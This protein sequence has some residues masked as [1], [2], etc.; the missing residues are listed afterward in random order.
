[1]TEKGKFLKQF[2]EAFAASDV[3]YIAAHVTEDIE[4]TIV[5]DKTLK[6]KAAFIEAL[7]KMAVDTTGKA[8]IEQVITHGKEAAVRGTIIMETEKVRRFAF[9]DTYVFSGF[10]N[11]KIKQMVSFVQE[12]S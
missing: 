11:P 12:V 4:W 6:G 1:M 10:K 8:E 3:D 9:C 7:E 2:N 5:G